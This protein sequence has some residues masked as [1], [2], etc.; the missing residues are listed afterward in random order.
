MLKNNE[1]VTGKS[2]LSDTKR[3]CSKLDGYTGIV[4]LD[5]VFN[6]TV[7]LKIHG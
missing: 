2:K 1:M 4:G 7:G 6:L 3:S 5:N